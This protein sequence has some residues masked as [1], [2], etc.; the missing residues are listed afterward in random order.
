MINDYLRSERRLRQFRI[1]ISLRPTKMAE[2]T[3]R[4]ILNMN[5][6]YQLDVK[7]F[8]WNEKLQFER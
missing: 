5:L 4:K 2:R 3:S 1:E 6:K 7:R 8:V